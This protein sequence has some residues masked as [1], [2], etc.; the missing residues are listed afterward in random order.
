MFKS[1]AV[2]VLAPLGVCGCGVVDAFTSL[3][4][5]TPP[6]PS[7]QRLLHQIIRELL[8]LFVHVSRNPSAAKT[9]ASPRYF[10]TRLLAKGI[11]PFWD[12]R[13]Q[14]RVVVTSSTVVMLATSTAMQL[15]QMIVPANFPISI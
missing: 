15:H 7:R 2:R 11:P 14:G 4:G 13:T 8:C 5:D 12:S 10:S 6:R 9:V 1:C 3:S